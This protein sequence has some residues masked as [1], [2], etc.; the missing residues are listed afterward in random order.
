MKLTIDLTELATKLAH[1][2]LI[3]K[4][5]DESKLFEDRK[6]SLQVYNDHALWHF[7]I[8][9]AYYYNVLEQIANEEGANV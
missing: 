5:G 2:D 7:D 1:N 4:V 3:Q 6:D 9:F 8:K